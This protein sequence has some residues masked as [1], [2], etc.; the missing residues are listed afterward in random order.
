[1]TK[2]TTNL[3]QATNDARELDD[4]KLEAICGGWRPYR[5]YVPRASRGGASERI[6]PV[7]DPS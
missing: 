4:A 5:A 1:M 6:L 2:S 7:D 3:N